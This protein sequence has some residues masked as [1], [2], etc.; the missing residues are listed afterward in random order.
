MCTAVPSAIVKRH[1]RNNRKVLPYTKINDACQCA[2]THLNGQ[3][4]LL[5]A[6]QDQHVLIPGAA[7]RAAAPGDLQSR[8]ARPPP[9]PPPPPPWEP[10]KWRETIFGFTAEKWTPKKIAHVFNDKHTSILDFVSNSVFSNPNAAARIPGIPVE[11]R[12]FRI[13][14]Q[15][16]NSKN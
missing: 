8:A 10:S 9:P 2:V 3:H 12:E 6:R 14:N 11:F 7:D 1:G 13:R 16:R 5:H 4:W 15:F